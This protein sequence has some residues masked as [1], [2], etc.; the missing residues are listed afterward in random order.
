ML[1][2]V[3]IALA[4][5]IVYLDT[6]AVAQFMISQPLIACPIWGLITGRP[7]IGL[8]FGVVFELIWLGSLP[9]GAAKIP[10]G[11]VG[12]LVATALAVRVPPTSNGNPAW[13]SL[14]IAALLGIL[15][16]R[17]GTE[18]TPLVRRV[19]VRYS[20]HVVNA[21][22]AG[23]RGRFSMLFLGAIGIHLLA[24]FL[25]TAVAFGVGKA[26]MAL[27]L[28]KF[29]TFG[30]SSVLIA[31]T[32]KLFFSLWPGMLG[33]GVAVIA[34]RFVNRASLGWFALTAALGLGVGCLCL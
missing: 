24:G 20:G 17:F 21:A 9:V 10:E 13:I 28:G 15:V 32:D 30:L 12:A 25:L 2:A 16:A 6:T 8:F 1:E 14:T 7:E 18:V 29:S 34:C 33:A 11:N 5:A 27:Y 3:W 26:I 23:R 31:E 19:L 22:K 4:G